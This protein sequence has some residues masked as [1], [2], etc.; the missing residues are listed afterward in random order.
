VLR[1]YRLSLRSPDGIVKSGSDDGAGAELEQVAPE[2]IAQYIET[3]R[4]S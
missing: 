4:P 1:A 3:L 2:E